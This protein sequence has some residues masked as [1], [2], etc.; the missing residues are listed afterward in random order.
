MIFPA[1]F[2]ED[3]NSRNPDF[4]GAGEGN[5]TLVISLEGTGA[6]S[7]FN[8]RS[9]KQALIGIL[10]PKQLVG[11]VRKNPRSPGP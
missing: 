5:R 6:S 4:I 7:D 3:A 2:W 1:R 11:A 9:D 10:D 8:A